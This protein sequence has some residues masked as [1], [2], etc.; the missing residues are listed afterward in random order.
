MKNFKLDNHSKIN[1]G[2]LLPEGYFD[3]FSEKMSVHLAKEEQSKA[4][5]E[6]TRIK[7]IS[8][9]QSRTVWYYAIAACLLLMLSIPIYRTFSSQTEEL[10]VKTLENYLADH[11]TITEDE[12]I[13]FLEKED[14]DK[15]QIELNVDETALEETLNSNYNIEEYLID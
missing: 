12:I 10:D 14:I 5:N 4:E 2:F 13:S 15:I 7:V 6:S 9:F 8:M 11:S 1:S 3:A